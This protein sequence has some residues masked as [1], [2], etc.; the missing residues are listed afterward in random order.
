MKRSSDVL[1]DVK[2]QFLLSN[3]PSELFVLRQFLVVSS[4]AAPSCGASV[5]LAKDTFGAV[6][7]R[8]VQIVFLFS[9]AVSHDELRPRSVASEKSQLMALELK[10]ARIKFLE[11]FAA[12][13]P[14]QIGEALK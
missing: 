8:R 5:V 6:H 13:D 2:D 1:R 10:E 3:E 12:F 9:Y 11:F 4:H 7:I 14:A